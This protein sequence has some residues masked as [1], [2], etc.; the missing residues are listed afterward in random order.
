M[1]T[2]FTRSN[3]SD[4]PLPTTLDAAHREITSLRFDLK[5]AKSQLYQPIP[6]VNYDANTPSAS[7]EDADN[8]CRTMQTALTATNQ[9]LVLCKKELDDAVTKYRLL[10]RD[11]SKSRDADRDTHSATQD[12]IDS[13]RSE[14][15]DR[16][17]DHDREKAIMDKKL[18]CVVHECAKKD[19]HIHRL[20]GNLR[21]SVR[22]K[23]EDFKV[24]VD[25]HGRQKAAHA[26]ELS[27][28]AGDLDQTI[29][30]HVQAKAANDDLL[31]RVG[32]AVGNHNDIQSRLDKANSQIVLLHGQL[33]LHQRTI[34][35]LNLENQALKDKIA[36]QGA[37]IGEL[38]SEIAQLRQQLAGHLS[39]VPTPVSSSAPAVRGDYEGRIRA[40]QAQID[41]LNTVIP[42]ERADNARL[43]GEKE[44]LMEE[45]ASS[46]KALAAFKPTLERANAAKD[47]AV[48][49]AA[50]ANKRIELLLRDEA[51]KEEAH[52]AE[53]A[54]LMAR[55]EDLLREVDRLKDVNRSLSRQLEKS[56]GDKH[57]D[58]TNQ[59]AQHGTELSALEAQVNAN[60]L[61]I[62]PF[63]SIAG[64]CCA[65]MKL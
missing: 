32:E 53:R 9:K 5:K 30:D 22:G 42:R 54:A 33:D 19:E 55:I 27:K 59:Q 1:A 38:E 21:Q 13:V 31:D 45:L 52:R 48:A 56:H 65:C 3:S 18:A 24:L 49:A 26:K 29:E 17:R 43:R 41:D 8:K 63:L 51:D 10:V 28:V 57:L 25:A 20:K 40:L 64:I 6:T 12:A 7:I 58:L 61:F 35:A 46:K 15:E 37:R 2:T 60:Y 47:T 23:T 36:Q 62:L 4:G 16:L 11:T 50:A 39:T 34:D 14:Y 44:K